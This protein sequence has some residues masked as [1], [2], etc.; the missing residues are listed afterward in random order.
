[1]RDEAGGAKS[2]TTIRAVAAEGLY[3]IAQWQKCI[4]AA[5]NEAHLPREEKVGLIYQPR[6]T[7]KGF[8]YK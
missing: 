3:Q 1:M 2:D 4:T 8:T 5:K 6:V 7:Q